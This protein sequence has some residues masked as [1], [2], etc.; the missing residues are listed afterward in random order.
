MLAS[1]IL[2]SLLEHGFNIPAVLTQP[3]RAAERGQ[4]QRTSPVKQ[5]ALANRLAV[6]QPA[7][8]KRPDAQQQLRDLAPELL[9]VVAYGQMLPPEVLEIPVRGCVNLHFSVLPRWRGAAPI[10]HALIAGDDSTGLSL[11]QMDA[12][13]DTGP[14]LASSNCTIDP[15]DTA[16]TL[17]RRMVAQ[18]RDWLPEQIERLLRAELTASPQTGELSHASKLQ[19]VALDFSQSAQ[20]LDRLVRGLSP[21]PGAFTWCRDQRLRILDSA[22]YPA[23][24]EADPGTIIAC[25][26]EHLRIACGDGCLDIKTAQLANRRA[27]NATQLYNGHRELFQPGTLLGGATPG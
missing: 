18:A 24:D 15:V 7:S 8:L 26:Q 21:R 10:Q 22:L 9:V 13:L 12:G 11:I 6:L 23:D 17:T 5:L 25:T 19:A 4:R 2:G 14:L 1:A 27:L 16:E 3:D 20:Q